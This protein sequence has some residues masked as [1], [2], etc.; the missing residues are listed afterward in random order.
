MVCDI[1]LQEYPREWNF[2]RKRV[3]QFRKRHSSVTDGEA[4]MARLDRLGHGSWVLMDLFPSTN[5]VVFRLF[6]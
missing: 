6:A 3:F 2:R 5:L 4:S 1:G